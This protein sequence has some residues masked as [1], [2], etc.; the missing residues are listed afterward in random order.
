MD[1]LREHSGEV[2]AYDDQGVIQASAKTWGELIQ[3]LSRDAV[4]SLTLFYVPPAN[5]SIVG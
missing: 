1:A 3:K 2:I 4:D 5:L